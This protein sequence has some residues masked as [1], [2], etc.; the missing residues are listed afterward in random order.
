MGSMAAEPMSEP[1]AIIGLSCKFAGDARCP[2]ELWKMLVEGRNAWSQIP[3]SRFNQKGFFDPDPEKLDTMHVKGGHFIEEDV[4]LFDA[5]FFNF[6]S[7]LAAALDPQFRLQLE[8]VY[9]ALENAGLPIPHVAGSNTS[10]YAS[11]WKHDYRDGIIRDEQNLPRSLETG[12]GSAYLAGRISHFFDLRGA[13]MTVDTACSTSAV[14]LHQAVQSLRSGEADM[15]I[16]GGS[17]L[18]LSPE[19]FVALGTT[20]FLSPDGKSYAFDSRA[21]GYG[22]GEGVAT[23]VIKRLKDA[24][25]AGDPVRAVIRETLLNHDGKKDSF[26]SPSQAAQVK[27]MRACYLN[28]G[29]DP[30]DT[31]YVEAHGT[32]T[33]VG[34][35]IETGA[36]ASVFQTPGGQRDQLLRI[37]SVK[38]NIGHTGAT[39]GLAGIIKVVLSLENRV[40]PPSLNFENVNPALS[41]E[42]AN[43]QVVR[44]PI[45]WLLSQNGIRRASINS[46]G[47][48]GTNAHV[49]LESADSFVPHINPPQPSQKY[50][51]KV[52]V[53][54]AKTE[55]ACKTTITRLIDY[56]EEKKGTVNEEALL[57]NVMYTLGQ[58]RTLFP[59]IAAH[60]V[61]FSRGIDEVITA[62]SS[63]HFQPRRTS[64]RPRIGMVFTGQ[65]AQW[66][67]MGRELIIAYPPFKASLEER[68]TYLKELGANWSL[69]DELHRDAENTRVNDTEI[70]IPICVALQISLVRLLRAWGVVPTAVTS[71]SS[72]EI[73]AAYAVG[74]L[75]YKSA[76][77]VAYHRAVLTAQKS[78]DG[79]VSGAMIAIGTSADE[80]EVYLSQVQSG[81]AVAACINSPSSVTVAGDMS[82][83]KEIEDM[84]KRD[85][86]FARRLRVKTAYHSHHMD[87]V[88]QPYREAL[89]KHHLEGD[90]LDNIAFSSPVTGGRIYSVDDLAHPDHWVDSLTQPVRFVEAVTDMVLGDFDPSGTSIDIVIEVGP[91]SALGGPFKEII[92]LPEFN[93]I[94]IPYYSCLVRNSNARD[95]MQDLVAHLLRE[96]QL[97]DLGPINF[98]WGKWPHVQVAS[99][100]PSYPWDHKTRHWHES[101]M[102]RAICGR[103]QSPHELLG[104]SSPWA[105]PETPSWRHIFR[106]NSSP[107][108]RDHIF[109]SSI[110]Y[111]AAGFICRAIE[112]ISQFSSTRES[113]RIIKGY[114]MRNFEIKQALVLSESDQGVEIE[115]SLRNSDDQIAQ[116]QGWMHFTVSSVALEDAKWTQHASGIISVQ[117]EDMSETSQFQDPEF[118]RLASSYT[119]RVVHP[120]DFYSSMRSS[121]I[122]YGSA[123]QNISSVVQ[124]IKLG[125]SEQRF[126]LADLSTPTNHIVHPT[127]LDSV[128]Q[129]AYTTLS[130]IDIKEGSLKVPQAISSL[131]VGNQI[132]REVGHKFRSRASRNRY[133]A[134]HLRADI[135]VYSEE[136][137]ASS[138]VIKMEGLVLRSVG[139]GASMLERQQ[140]KPWEKEICSKITWSAD[141][142]LATPK[143]L[144]ALKETF[145]TSPDPNETQIVLDLR[146][147]CTYFIDNALQSLTDLDIQQL[148]GHHKKYHV[149]LV[150]QLQ[151]A[152]DGKLGPGSAQWTLDDA[153]ERRRRLEE[154]SKASVNGE[155]TCQLGPHLAAMLRREV[156]PLEIMME[157]KLL[158]RYYSNMLKSD[159]SF[160][161]A[162]DLLQRIVHKNPR[163]RILE[164]GGGTGGETRYAL[165]ALG[166]VKTGGPKA[167]LYHFTDISAAFFE[168]AASEFPEWSEIMQYSMFDVEKDPSIQGFE[169]G[170]YDIVIACQ[171]LHA[172]KSM[173][174]TMANVR[175]LLKPGGKLLMVETTKDQVD[176]Q[177]VF[178]LVP[179]WW[180]SEEEERSSG[181]SLSVPFWDK[182]LKESGF[183]GVDLEIHDCESEEFYSFSTIMS[184]AHLSQAEKPLAEDVVLITSDKASPPTEWVQLLQDTVVSTTERNSEVLSIHALETSNNSVFAGNI[185]VFLGEIG[186][187]LLANLS[188]HELN[189]MKGMATSCKGLLWITRGGAVESEH[190]T[191]GLAVGLMRTMRNEYVGRK[192]LTLDLDPRASP[193]TDVSVSAIVRVL[194]AEFAAS[195]NSFMY[196]TLDEF[197]Y[198][199]RDG[200][201]LVPRL[202]KNFEENEKIACAPINYSQ[203]APFTTDLFH[204]PEHSLSLQIGVPGQLDTLSYVRTDQ[205]ELSESSIPDTMIEIEARAFGLNDRDVMVAL[206]EL[207]DSTLGM[208]CSG[209]ITK[210]GNIAMSKGYQP[211][212][213]VF[214]MMR[215]PMS[216]RVRTEWTNLQHI[217]PTLSFKQAA[218]IPVAFSIAVIGLLE[219]ARVHVGQ[220][221]LINSAAGTVGQAAV[222]VAQR[223]GARVF[224]TV[225]SPEEKNYMISKYGIPEDLVFSH[226]NASF[227]GG[228]LAAT[229]GKG[230]D[231]VLNSLSGSL[232]QPTLS[233]IAPFGHFIDIAV[234]DSQTN[235]AIKMDPF[236]RPITFS[237]VDLRMLMHHRPESVYRA[238]TQVTSMLQEN[239]L[240]LDW[241]IINHPIVET[242]E[243]FDQMVKGNHL[244]KVVLRA[245]PQD[246]VRVLACNQNLKLSPFASY[247]LVG[248]VGGI[249]R[250]VAAWMVEKGA[251]NL[252]LLSRSAGDSPKTGRFITELSGETGCRVKAI[253]CDVSNQTQLESALQECKRDGL[254]PIRGVVQ[255]AMVLQDSLLE[256]MTLS[257]WQNA[258]QPKVAGTWNLHTNFAQPADLDFFVIL[259]SNVGTLGNASQSNYAAGGTF[260]DAFAQ[261]RVS[262]GL[263]CVS[264][265]LPAVK[266]VGYVAETA[267]V[268][269]RMM[270]LGHM[271]LDEELVL[272]S[273]QLGRDA[274]FGGL[275]YRQSKEQKAAGAEKESAESLPALLAATSSLA[276]AERLVTQAVA[277]KLADVFSM[278]IDGVD[279]KLSPGAHG[280]DSLVAV[281]LRNLFR[282]QIGAEISTFEILQSTSLAGLASLA[283]SKSEHAKSTTST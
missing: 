280:V 225:G 42:T 262:R 111:P 186:Q 131:W 10:V 166:S 91:H 247:L 79:T 78:L 57:E 51:T 138:P 74:A 77:A 69:L 123:F 174:N 153:Q 152:K 99:D 43:I 178:G 53:L 235:S 49:I 180:L 212:D 277:Q 194:G 164:I 96:G 253:S 281:E 110:L 163:A 37:G 39:S 158:Y 218:S 203:G 191:H 157:G 261:W 234:S 2:A 198:A 232:L 72:G 38:T 29:L 115:T 264:I 142:S 169:S 244:G 200:Q 127:T 168:A 240:Q 246:T 279:M 144:K 278:L 202:Q 17:N 27:L 154:A 243:A 22:R 228:V 209:I 133:D 87:P 149:W 265:D 106:I 173:S 254:P 159:R 263:P 44:E 141:M 71:H 223:V 89:D 124:S 114:L 135:T 181:P 147:V 205:K 33:K 70:S 176:V 271:V 257:A 62:L 275:R 188:E 56:L 274:R 116:S 31:Q 236:P 95:S 272:N 220:S 216:S 112:A 155:M 36:I 67:A 52:L 94:T 185:C 175:K 15:S 204:Q 201:I 3:S 242:V 165:K 63:P 20:G 34:D 122:K 118:E 30:L 121:G 12:T 25:K 267:G 227:A 255:G 101:R 92:Q 18:T 182:I 241:K 102:P 179:G 8:S 196:E 1:I 46:F 229:N 273:S 83:V 120:D 85:G 75:D 239:L 50:K 132:P 276:D 16:I 170:S 14:A 104:S 189:G 183:T 195:P 208:E 24:V 238:L 143:N 184:T 65:G 60:R 108:V 187:D 190:P 172:T 68:E 282:H 73:A 156:A 105:N 210:A 32:G 177:F 129:A 103:S 248:G 230:V 88:A 213:R 197:E 59:W 162:V 215:G 167:S 160:Q 5:S 113:D 23:L 140:A 6:P 100:L 35:P 109:D 226:G 161:H 126:Y 146:R 45:K 250:S 251:R 266:S 148:D 41:L 54:S 76:M 137:N 151:L 256:Q 252:I 84:A 134:R 117:Y 98:P 145:S 237:T 40:I 55:D 97:F 199:E 283:A 211:G 249:G 219:M 214:G 222:K 93:G 66:H 171:V 125:K 258:V 4:G 217:P 128:I 21:N 81:K 224:I 86:I 270:R 206:G 7:E 192:F 231:I 82:A 119:S 58:R 13:S 245:D 28:A 150:D 259:S 90:Y 47:A 193:W 26:T 260:Q 130:E 269:A 11:I 268:G 107:W 207:E 64:Q 139:A 136:P 80:T 19:T 61:P 9:E 221:V 233:V 48:S